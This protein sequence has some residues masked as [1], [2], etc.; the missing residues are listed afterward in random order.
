MYKHRR[1]NVTKMEHWNLFEKYGLK[2]NERWYEHESES[3][4]END[5]LKLLWDVNIQCD[6]I[7]EARRPD[8]VVINK[9]EKS[10]LI[11]DIAILGDIRVHE[12]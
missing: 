3:V 6:H 2:S 12:K 11:I 1:D 7:I 9:Q 10:C 4:V 5:G 8:I